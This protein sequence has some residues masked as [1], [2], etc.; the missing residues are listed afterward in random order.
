MDVDEKYLEELFSLPVNL[1][2]AAVI[3]GHKFYSSDKLKQSF[4]KAFRKEGR[5]QPV[6]DDVE[7]MVEKEIITPCYLNKGL[8]RFLMHRT[9]GGANKTIMGFYHMKIKKIY[10]LIDNNINIFGTG[11]SDMLISTTMHECMHLLAGTKSSKFLS[12]FRKTVED[13]YKHAFQNIF[14]LKSKP[15]DVSN[16]VDYLIKFENKG[17]SDINKSLTQYFK[18]L[19]GEFKDMTRFDEADFQKMLTGYIVAIKLLL[20]NFDVF[21]KT[22]RKFVHVIGG[23]RKAYQQ[24]FGERN[25]FTTPIQEAV[26]PSEIICVYSELKP[27]DSK[28]KRAFKAL[29]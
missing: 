18:L 29:S 22:A 24:T 20:T 9:F 15:K 25:T 13:Y 10:V 4:I 1:Q 27:T 16:I 26:Y 6:A 14:L 7:K 17:S 2:V 23:F 19:E 12:I 28:I 8:I 3:D 21:V 5:G 11:S